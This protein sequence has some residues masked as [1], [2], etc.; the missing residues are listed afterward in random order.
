[1]GIR[2]LNS[3]LDERAHHAHCQTLPCGLLLVDGCGWAFH[4][5][6]EMPASARLSDYG[7]LHSMVDTAVASMRAAGLSPVAYLSLIHI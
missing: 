3:W 2:G 7:T 1:M 6:N 5:L 4:L